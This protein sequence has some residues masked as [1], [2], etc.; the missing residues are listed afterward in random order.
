MSV[1][2]EI[3]SLMGHVEPLADHVEAWAATIA[4]KVQGAYAAFAAEA[5]PAERERVRALLADVHERA[6]RRMA[7]EPVSKR[8]IE[9]AHG[10]H[11]LGLAGPGSAPLVT[12]KSWFPTRLDPDGQFFGFGKWELLDPDW[13]EALTSWLLHLHHRAPFNDQ[14]VTLTIPD[15]VKLAIAGD[16]G[17][18][19]WCPTAPSTKVA[20]ALAAQGA[21][22][23]IHLGDVYYAGKPEECTKA[24]IDVWPLGSRGGFTLNSNHEMYSGAIPYFTATL[25]KLFTL[26]KGCSYFA[27]QNRDWLIVGLDTA[28]AADPWNLYLDGNIEGRQ[29]EWLAALPKDKRVILLSH[30]QG[31]DEKGE[32]PTA[33]YQQVVSALGRAPD[34]WYWGHLHNGI[35]Y[36]EY[37]GMRSRCV[38]H[39]AIPY[40]AA[41]E[42]EHVDAVLWYE[43]ERAQD[44]TL[45]ARVLN[46]LAV[47]ELDGASLSEAMLDENGGTRWSSTS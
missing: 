7:G 45:P 40:G 31:L 38:G 32:Q 10:A 11:P 36:R 42:L 46:G 33:V 12:H 1:V 17:T 30:H 8:G 15:R 3:E 44:P 24:L 22:Y 37:Q 9:F 5:T 13:T 21:D 14:P 41:D 18:G 28:Y 47:V 26:Q 34:Y 29:L 23:T 35:V 2:A 16:F 27:L 43:S 20:R 39:G 4:G 25:P 6:A 19:P